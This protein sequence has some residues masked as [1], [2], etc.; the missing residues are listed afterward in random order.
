MPGYEKEA[1]KSDTAKSFSD[2]PDD[3]WREN[4]ALDEQSLRISAL[5]I[6]PDF[7]AVR[8]GKH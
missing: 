4:R 2:G 3:D 8:N 5:F 1:F 7:K 6:D